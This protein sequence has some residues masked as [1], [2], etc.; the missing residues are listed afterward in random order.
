MP[1]ERSGRV[2]HVDPGQLAV[3]ANTPQTQRA[4]VA[5]ARKQVAVQGVRR[6]AP[7]LAAEVRVQQDLTLGHAGIG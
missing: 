6:Q 5:R 4:V 1:C 7:Q 2:A 3:P